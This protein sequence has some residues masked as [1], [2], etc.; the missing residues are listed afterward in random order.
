M[1]IFVGF[2]FNPRD[3]WIKDLAIP[4][5]KAFNA[6][7]VT[8]EDMQGQELSEEVQQRIRWSDGLIGFRT[9]REQLANGQWDSH[10]WVS[11]ELTLAIA[12][13]LRVVEV[14]EAGVDQQ[15]GLAGNRQWIPYEESRREQCLVDI[16]TTLGRW[17]QGRSI[18]LQLLP[19]ETARLIR[20]VL[21]NAASRCTYKLVRG[22]WE[23]AETEA[24]IR[25]TPSG[26]IVHIPE[27]HP[28]ASVQVKV[29][30][31]GRVYSSD[32]V[33]LKSMDVTLKEE[34]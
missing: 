2:G 12:A 31:A 11:D 20:P 33:G 26:L 25:P 8:G 9:R 21:A 22:H 10:R 18:D 5:L 24:K 32:Y 7:V 29:V 28:D 6:E 34:M 23:S 1:R 4:L 16:A 30:A 3:S 27:V 15:G 13:N 19:Q 14:R 17:T